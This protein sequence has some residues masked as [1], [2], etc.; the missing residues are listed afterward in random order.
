MKIWPSWVKIRPTGVRR[1]STVPFILVPRPA[2][3]LDMRAMKIWCVVITVEWGWGMSEIIP[4]L[5]WI[6]ILWSCKI[7]GSIKS[8]WSIQ[9]WESLSIKFRGSFIKFR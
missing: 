3:R 6:I 7:R 9:I 1:E 4:I 2:S 8:L 5:D